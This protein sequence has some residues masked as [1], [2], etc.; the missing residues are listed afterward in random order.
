MIRV[1]SLNMFLQNLANNRGRLYTFSLR[2]CF[3][4]LLELLID[5]N[6][7][8][9]HHLALEHLTGCQTTY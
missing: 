5:P 8:A 1:L 9:I 4:S 2:L 6:R 7:D 3:E